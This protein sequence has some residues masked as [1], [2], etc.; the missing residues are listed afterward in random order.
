MLAFLS[1]EEQEKV[2]DM[3]PHYQ[4][5]AENTVTDPDQLRI[6]LDQI[7]KRGYSISYEDFE[8]GQT[9]SARLYSAKWQGHCRH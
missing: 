2:L 8:E 6:E 9:G 4:K 3:L 7:R 5:L 1:L